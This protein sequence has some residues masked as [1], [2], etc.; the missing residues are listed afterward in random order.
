MGHI[1]IKFCNPYGEELDIQW[2]GYHVPSRGEIVN[3]GC[4]GQEGYDRR[5]IK[6]RWVSHCI[7]EI[8]TEVINHFDRPT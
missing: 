4:Q 7:V 1:L 6:I 5:V 8:S 3:I 2:L